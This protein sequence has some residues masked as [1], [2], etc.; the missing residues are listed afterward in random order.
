[1]EQKKFN[2]TITAVFPNDKFGEGSLL[3]KSI[4]EEE[5]ARLAEIKLGSRLLIKKSKKK[6]SN[7]SS[8]YFME[9]L[10]PFETKKEPA[11]VAEDSDV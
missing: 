8:F 3:T 4:G 6:S 7:G 9:I 5:L 1:M 10:P 11:T 2:T